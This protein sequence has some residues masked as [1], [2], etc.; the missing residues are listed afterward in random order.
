[1]I[2]A[3][4]EISS[5]KNT[6][7]ILRKEGSNLSQTLKE[8]EDLI[9]YI[10]RDHEEL[11]DH[12][13]ELQDSINTFNRIAFGRIT[14]KSKSKEKIAKSS[15]QINLK[16]TNNSVSLASSRGRKIETNSTNSNKFISKKKIDKKNEEEKKL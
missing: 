10:K 6:V 3:I 2:L 15:S 13:N 16:N 9:N 4:S 1:M 5:L 14:G 12:R 8:K 7:D 11:L